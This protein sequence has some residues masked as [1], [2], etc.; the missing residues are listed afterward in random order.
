MAIGKRYAQQG[1]MPALGSFPTASWSTSLPY[2]GTRQRAGLSSGG[3]AF[4][5]GTLIGVISTTPANEQWT[6]SVAGCTGTITV[7]VNFTSGSVQFSF[8]QNAPLSTVL[9]AIAAAV[10]SWGNGNLVVTGT[11]GTTYILTFA[12]QLGNVAI[13]G[14]WA[15]QATTGTPALTNTQL[16]SSAIQ[17]DAYNASYNNHIGGAL[18]W[19]VRTGA[20]G[21]RLSSD[22]GGLSQNTPASF[23][24]FVTGFFNASDLVGLDSNAL[25]LPNL[26]S[27]NGGTIIEF[28]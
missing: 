11:P 7:S 17:Y 10:P 8:A 13:G 2:G 23:P 16:G 22:I 5:Q 14:G 25:T 4:L 15:A 18:Q 6:L 1:L 12:N 28:N 19:D 3:Q 26:L 27:L 20:S 24:F 9:A 21:E